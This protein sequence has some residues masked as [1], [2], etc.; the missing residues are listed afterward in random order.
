MQSFSVRTK[1]ELCRLAIGKQCCRVAELYGM[2]L[3]STVFSHREMR[4][5]SEQQ[6]VVRRAATLLER[7]FG[8]TALPERQGTKWVV[9]ITS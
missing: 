1:S 6:A 9:H 4:I 5:A 8:V 7:T 3:F 2:L